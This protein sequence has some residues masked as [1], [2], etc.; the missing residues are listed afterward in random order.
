MIER[1]KP[2]MVV[3]DNSSEFTSIAIRHRLII[4]ALARHHC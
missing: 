1:G 2:K 3:S 4:A